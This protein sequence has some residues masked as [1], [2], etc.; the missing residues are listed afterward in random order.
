MDLK[1][2]GAFLFQPDLRDLLRVEARDWYD[3]ASD[4]PHFARFRTGQPTKVDEGW[5]AWLDK[6]ATDTANGMTW[7]RVHVIARGI[8]LNDYL[9]FEFGEQ[10]TRNAAA[11][12]EI[13]ILEVP[14]DSL[15]LYSDVFVADGYRVAIST[16][17]DTGKFL[18][19]DDATARRSQASAAECTWTYAAP[20]EEWWANYQH[21]K[22][23]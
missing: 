23:A 6:I 9:A 14:A 2:L 10:Y 21:R 20:F 1:E 15:R 13:R 8:P 12:E 3:S 16:Y 5:Q 18:Y 11:G 4:D 7:R 19:A 22:A 17:D